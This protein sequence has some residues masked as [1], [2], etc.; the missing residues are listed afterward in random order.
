M[1]EAGYDCTWIDQYDI[2]PFF[3]LPSDLRLSYRT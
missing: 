3:H 1:S 2:V